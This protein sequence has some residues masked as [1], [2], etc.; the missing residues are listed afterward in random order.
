LFCTALLCYR[1]GTT[2]ALACTHAA[3]KADKTPPPSTIPTQRLKPPPIWSRRVGAVQLKYAG[4][5][6]FLIS[7]SLRYPNAD[8]SK[9]ETT[10]THVLHD[11]LTKRTKDRKQKSHLCL[12]NPCGPLGAGHHLAPFFAPTD[13]LIGSTINF[14]APTAWPISYEDQSQLSAASSSHQTKPPIHHTEN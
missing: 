10:P 8:D 7:L 14:S 6:S 9:C 3:S 1:T 5:T 11:L 4:R 13:R 12:V 2:T